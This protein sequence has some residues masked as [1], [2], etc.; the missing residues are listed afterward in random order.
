MYRGSVLVRNAVRWW[1]T[2]ALLAVLVLAAVM[3]GQRML[4]RSSSDGMWAATVVTALVYSSIIM[5]AGASFATAAVIGWLALTR[6]LPIIENNR[7]LRTLG[8]AVLGAFVVQVGLA[9]WT[10]F[11]GEPRFIRAM[12]ERLRANSDIVLLY[13]AGSI[14]F[15]LLPR[16][17]VARLRKPSMYFT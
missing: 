2:G 8:I 11:L 10:V 15:M 6:R 4:G 12:I 14:A 13:T 17:L 5:L 16:L 1:V 9:I 7:I 3:L